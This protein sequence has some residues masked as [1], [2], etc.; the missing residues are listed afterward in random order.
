MPRETLELKRGILIVEGQIL[1]GFW[2][3]QKPL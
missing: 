2:K 3:P 1:S